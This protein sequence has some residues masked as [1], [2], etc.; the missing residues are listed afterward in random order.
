VF[1]STANLYDI[2]PQG[3]I[4]GRRFDLSAFPWRTGNVP[5]CDLYL[6]SAI[7]N[8][9]NPGGTNNTGYSNPDFDGA[10][11]TAL[12]TLDDDARRAAH[13]QAQIVFAADLPSLPLFFRP[14][15]AAAAPRVIGVHLDPTAASVLWNLEEWELSVD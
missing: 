13:M 14:K 7:P 11:Q 1:E 8:A 6:T 15:L 5:P 10:C 12:T 9:Q 2:W 3:V 4:F